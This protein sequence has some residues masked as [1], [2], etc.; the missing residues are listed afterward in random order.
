MARFIYFSILKV[1]QLTYPFA[2]TN[3]KA[4]TLC[5]CIRIHVSGVLQLLLAHR[6]VLRKAH[7]LV[8]P[9]EWTWPCCS[10]IWRHRYLNV[11]RHVHVKLE[12]L[13]VRFFFFG[14]FGSIGGRGWTYIPFVDND[15]DGWWPQN[16]LG[17]HGVLMTFTD[18]FYHNFVVI[19]QHCI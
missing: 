3:R 19:L 10:L 7:I 18:I 12:H 13:N 15:M 5:S 4:V 8:L 11:H 16:L 2:Y 17:I 14:N 1:L 6:L 9:K